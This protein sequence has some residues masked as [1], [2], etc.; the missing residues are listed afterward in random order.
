MRTTCSSSVHGSQP[1]PLNAAPRVAKALILLLETAVI[2]KE[3][4]ALRRSQKSVRPI[5]PPGLDPTLHPLGNSLPILPRFP[6]ALL[7][8]CMAVGLE[9]PLLCRGSPS[10]LPSALRSPW[11]VTSPRNLLESFAD[12][13]APD[14]SSVLACL[15]T[16]AWE[17][18]GSKDAPPA[19]LP[20]RPSRALGLIMTVGL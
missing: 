1:E 8:R 15:S 19:G 6:G 12:F 20:V 3:S 13:T 7:R 18:L 5:G 10:H 9:L 16:P 11:P 2:S 17:L 14:C 4:T